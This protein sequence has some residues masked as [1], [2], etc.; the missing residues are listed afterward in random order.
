MLNEYG[1][2]DPQ[3]LDVFRVVDKAEDAARII[4][5]FRESRGRSGIH[6]PSGM[7]KSSENVP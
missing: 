3:D 5:E 2:I 6:L 1:Y 4:V 7:K